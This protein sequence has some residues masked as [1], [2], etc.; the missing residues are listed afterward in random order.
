MRVVLWTI[1]ESMSV[2]DIANNLDSL[3]TGVSALSS[4]GTTHL[5]SRHVMAL[6][7][8]F[9]KEGKGPNDALGG[10]I[11]TL[12]KTAQKAELVLCIPF[13]VCLCSPGLKVTL[14]RE[15]IPCS[16]NMCSTV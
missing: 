4:P 2:A 5:N 15:N 12:L 8:V 1:S 10:V 9:L 3:K 7:I 13:D 6:E 11:R 14:S 16:H